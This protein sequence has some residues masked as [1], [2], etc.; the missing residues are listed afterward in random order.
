MPTGQDDVI[1]IARE[2][3]TRCVDF[4]RDNR[5]EAMDDLM[6]RV[7][8]QW[9]DDVKLER[10]NQNRPVLTINRMPQFIR[11]VTGDIRINSPAI[12]VR[13]V[14]SDADIE[15]AKILTGLIRHIEQISS[16]HIA[17]TTAADGAAACGM[18]HFRVVLEYA[19]DDTFDLDARIKRIR[20][21][22]AVYW[23]PDSEELTRQDAAFC[24]VIAQMSLEEYKQKYPDSKMTEW[25]EQEI[26]Q[27]DYL[28][29]WW[30]DEE[31]KV[32]EYW[33][34]KPE[35]KRLYL[36]ADGRVVDELDEQDR[37]MV[38]G[39]REVDSSKVVQYILNGDEILEGPLD[40]PGKY[41]PIIPVLGEEVHVGDEVVRH[42]IIRYAKDP[43][44][45][46]NY[47][48]TTAAETIALAP[49]TPWIGTH[50]QFEGSEAL[51]KSANRENVAYLAYNPDGEAP[52]PTRVPGAEIPMAVV[53]EAGI[54]A[55]DMK[56]VIG[57]YDAGLG[58][59]SN[60]TSGRAILARQREGD[61]GT[62]VYVD[63]LAI[64]IAHAGRVLVDLIPHLYSEKKQLRILGEDDVEVFENVNQEMLDDDSGLPYIKHDLSRG[65]YDVTVSTGPSY[66]TKRQESA[67]AMMQFVQ[68]APSVAQ[69]VMDL[70]VKNM[71]WPGAEKIQERLKRMIPAG[72][73]DDLDA[74]RPPAPAPQP[75]P[76]E[77]KAAADAGKAKAAS[78][79][80]A[81]ET[82]GIE[83]DNAAK[84]LELSTQLG[85]M[86]GMIRQAVTEAVMQ[87]I[88]GMQNGGSAMPMQPPP[89]PLAGGPVPPPGVI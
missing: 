34:K 42:G 84:Q 19:D 52:P 82:E 46:Y 63:N 3:F 10:Q 9:P 64:A 45:L 15:T 24:F 81:A 13:P 38:Q 35:K 76:K 43:Q 61:V 67:E 36:L 51:W 62:F 56:A 5:S 72:I 70:I 25:D 14:D 68:A 12:K 57:I 1:R 47:W 29:H 31:I 50:K 79:K 30:K 53:N 83:L 49:K 32:A 75:D 85:E 48:R 89:D 6:F 44:L 87:T 39:E 88:V 80:T 54:A 78:A 27:R 55:D 22:F 23:D 73:D 2:R 4:D 37:A 74:E 17:Y 77:I 20:N 28:K 86:Q 26:G 33:C 8:R 58:A 65:K 41:I 21:P 60:E 16:A 59:R 7:G 71:D 69:V 66:S 11:Q 18:G 40:H